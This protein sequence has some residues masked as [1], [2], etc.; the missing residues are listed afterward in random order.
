M[1][2]HM[3]YGGHVK[4]LEHIDFL[5]DLGFHFGE[6]VFGNTDSMH[7]WVD[8]GTR[9][10]F[11]DGFF[12]IAHGPR[13]GAAKDVNHLWNEYVPQLEQAV[14]V[15]HAM[16]IDFLTVH[17]W[18]DQ[19]FLPPE[20]IGEKAQMM[21]RVVSFGRDHGVGVALENLSE[22]AVDLAPILH[23]VEDL[24]ITLDIGHGQ[25]LSKKNRAYE[26]LE[27]AAGRVGHVHAHDNRGGNDAAADL[28]LPIGEGIVDFPGVIRCLLD[29][30]YDGTV[31]IELPPSEI[32]A[33]RDRLAAIA[34]KVRAEG[35][36][37]A[38]P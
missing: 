1:V 12:L 6:V 35:S 5:R 37:L 17:L 27:T 24:L 10:R 13:E 26:I 2:R 31:T 34:E 19:R 36:G 29:H 21:K 9:N 38:G 16:E 4:T 22:R 33:S 28:H 18:M 14:R 20:V 23:D 11:D 32:A 30:G 8:S 25:L 15:A 3:L 7:S